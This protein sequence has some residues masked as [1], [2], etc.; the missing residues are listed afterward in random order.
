M[1]AEKA[2]KMVQGT[3]VYPAP[4]GRNVPTFGQFCSTVP[5]QHHFLPFW[6]LL[7]QIPDIMSLHP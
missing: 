3:A 7:K 5:T 4:S 1:S 6:N 2:E